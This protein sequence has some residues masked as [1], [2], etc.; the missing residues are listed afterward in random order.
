M[1]D[2]VSR[3]YRIRIKLE[4]MHPMNKVPPISW[5]NVGTSTMS[6]SGNT[7]YYR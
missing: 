6:L 5:L 1:L 2:I 7:G 4:K 3:A